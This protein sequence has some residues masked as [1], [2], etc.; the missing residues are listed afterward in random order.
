MKRLICSIII[1]CAIAVIKP[2]SGQENTS[3][4][5]KCPACGMGVGMFVD[6]NATIRF[7]DASEPLVFDGPKCMFKY[8]SLIHI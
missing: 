6:T 5:L 2:A 3:D 4:T 1:I 8:L 7:N